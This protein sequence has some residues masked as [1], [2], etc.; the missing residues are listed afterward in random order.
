MTEI[1]PGP[2]L[3]IVG[4]TATGKTSLALSL[5]TFDIVKKL[6]AGVVI[7]SADSRQVYKGI[8]IVSGADM[9]ENVTIH[10]VSM[11]APDQDWSLAHFQKF[12]LPIIYQAWSENKLS[13]I[14]GG[15]GLYHDRLFAQEL[16]DQLGPDFALRENLDQMTLTEMQKLAEVKDGRAFA[17][18]TEDDKSNKRR[19]VRLIEKFDSRLTSAHL[20]NETYQVVAP[21]QLIRVGLTDEIENIEQKIKLRVIDRLEQGAIAEIEKLRTDYPNKKLPIFS[22]T[23]VKEINSYLDEKID[24]RTLISMWTVRERQYAKRQMTWFKKSPGIEWFK[25]SDLQ[26]TTKVKSYLEKSL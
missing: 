6:F 12:A 19:L 13:V 5:S 9:P 3:S 7:I 16:Q 20:N 11:I 23:G 10:G 18:M 8:E 1:L 14:V 26:L 22:A 2:L 25:A 24:Y 21:S 17:E 15:T 4:P